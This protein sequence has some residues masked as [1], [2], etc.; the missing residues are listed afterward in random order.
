MSEVVLKFKHGAK[1]YEIVKALLDAAS[2]TRLQS[3]V[4]LTYGV[5]RFYRLVRRRIVKLIGVD[6]AKHEWEVAPD[7]FYLMPCE[8]FVARALRGEVAL[9]DVSLVVVDPPWNS[10]KRGA[11]PKGLGISNM[12]YHVKVDPRSVIWAA[13]KLA[14]ASGAPLL[15]RYREPLP[16]KHSV[17]A[18]AEVE[19]M[20][21]RGAV[22]YGICEC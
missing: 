20:N 14:R 21:N 15:Y 6:V 12:P 19:V 9:G 4:D 22:Y 2:L 8:A 3:V 11:M 10:T 18:E 5:G 17:R 7:E 13:I 1:S 16:C